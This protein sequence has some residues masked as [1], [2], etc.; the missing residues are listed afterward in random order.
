MIRVLEYLFHE[1]R[2]RELRQFSLEK[3]S[4]QGHL[5][6]AFQYVKMSLKTT[7]E[8]LSTRVCSDRTRERMEG[9]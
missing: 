4:H 2:L 5:I 7:R 9:S 6:V 1:D 3:S 8:G